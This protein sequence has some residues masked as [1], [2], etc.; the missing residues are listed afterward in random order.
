M[1]PRVFTVTRATAAPGVVAWLVAGTIACSDGPAAPTPQSE[2]D[3]RAA[4]R[5]NE[6]AR[7]MVISHGSSPPHAS[8]TYAYVSLASWAAWRA[9]G[10]APA[11]TKPMPSPSAAAARAAAVVL[12]YIY[13]GASDFVTDE[14]RAQA[15]AR[16]ARGESPEASDAGEAVG[17]AVAR[18]AVERAQSD[19]ADATWDHSVPEGPGYFAGGTPAWPTWG[20]VRPWLV[21]SGRDMRASAPPEFESE[22]FLAALREVRQISDSRTPQQ[23][24]TALH[25]ADG[26]GTAT[27]PGHWNVIAADLLRRH[28]VRESDALR[29]FALVNV[30][31]ADAMIGCWDSKYAYW[32]LRPWEADASITTP[33]GRPN[34]PSYP[35]GHSCSSAAGAT[36]LAGLFP[37]EAEAL[38]AMAEEAGLSR[39]YGG[40]HYRFDLTA[41]KS[42]GRECGAL[43]LAIKANEPQFFATLGWIPQGTTLASR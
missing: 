33:I 8:R 22:G 38:H 13:P 21:A 36:V 43:A 15:L 37:G 3:A 41:G 14:L 32:Y 17:E 7:A 12:E 26:A 39:L 10:N 28:R 19:G 16:R 2:P 5:W 40:I 20:A 11:S 31:M 18:L 25:W 27:P 9:A 4:V 30:A 6:I 42:I 24:A 29:T 35:S 23:L 1:T 34:H